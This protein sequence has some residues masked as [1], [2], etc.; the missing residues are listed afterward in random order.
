M[1][2]KF[3]HYFFL[4]ECFQSARCSSREKILYEGASDIYAS[5][6]C[7][8]SQVLPATGFSID[9]NARIIS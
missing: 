1:L 6:L 4:T 9:A 8:A 7:A 3:T 5:D 2:T